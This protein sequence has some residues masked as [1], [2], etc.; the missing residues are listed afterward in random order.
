MGKAENTVA[1]YLVERVEAVGGLC[2]KVHCESERGFPDYLITWPNGRMKKV[3]TKSKDGVCSP[4]QA[5][6]H[7]QSARCRCL[8]AVL[9]TRELVD[10]FMSAYYGDYTESVDG[11]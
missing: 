9:Y 8:V 1:S 6:Y 7:R 3:E 10:E 5:R 2:D 4:T 11:R